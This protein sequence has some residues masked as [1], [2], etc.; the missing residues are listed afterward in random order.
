MF[1]P[2]IY[3]RTGDGFLIGFIGWHYSLQ[4]DELDAATGD[5]MRLSQ[6]PAGKQREDPPRVSLENK[7]APAEYF[8]Q[9]LGSTLQL[10]NISMILMGTLW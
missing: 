1:L 7:G 3:G 2:S 5:Y 10:F 6:S 4:A 8:E 9:T